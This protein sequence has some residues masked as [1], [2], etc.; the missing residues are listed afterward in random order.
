MLRRSLRRTPQTV[1]VA[2]LTG[3]ALAG[4]S[5][6]SAAH[7]AAPPKIVVKDGLTQPVFS[8]KDAIREHV[9]VEAGLDTDGDGKRD[10][11]NV[12]IVRPKES[13]AGLKVPVIMDASPYYDNLGRG[14][15]SEKK[16]YDA[17]GN[18][19]KFPLFYDNYFV[20]RGYAFLAV[21]AIGSN[22]SDGCPGVGESD[23]L[24]T[25]AVIDWLNGRAKA[26]K[27]DG[28]PV[29][30]SWT[31]GRTGM[32]GKSWDGTLANGVASTGVRGLET[33]VP[34]SAISSWYDYSRM[35]GV[36][37]WED[38]QPYLAD[39]VDTDP[40]AKCASVVAA[41]DA[42]EDDAT[43]DYNDYW[44]HR[45]YRNGT[46]GNAKNVRA[47]VF[48]YHGVNDLNV[49]DNHFAQWW[50]DLGKN[51]VVRKVWLSQTGH[52]DPFDI[53]R[54]DWVN[55]LHKWFDHELQKINNDALREPRADIEVGPDKWIT[56][57]S[58]PARDSKRVS[59]VPA[60][61]GS[62]GTKPAPH[63]TTGAFT[64]GP[65]TDGYGLPEADM[66]A[67]PTTAN[68]NR[69]AYV[70]A[71]LPATGRL[72]GTPDAKIKVKLDKPDA[73]VTALLV[74]YGTD[75]R[76]DYLG[77][78]SG[79]QTLTTEDCHGESIPTDD[80]CYKQTR[81]KTVT[82]DV[83]VVARGWM[84][85]QNR[86]SL[87][88]PSPLTPGT[89]YTVRWNTLSQEYVFKKGHRVALVLSGADY[90]YN[91]EK[92]TGAQVTIDLSGTS[93]T[94]PIVAGG[95]EAS[96]LVAPNESKGAWRGPQHVNLPRQ[97]KKLY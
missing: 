52:V 80:A 40:P 92:A 51:G 50:S 9:Y 34:I 26:T 15:E 65:G 11:V 7:A 69:L 77:A 84:D 87:S 75:T 35:N 8:Y 20:P 4:V 59:L 33:I 66:V 21:D 24:G 88:K 90:D 32:I 81:T 78:G 96:T 53:R 2:V 67:D 71:P 56:Q 10:R 46:F 82:S 83:N 68:P 86:S 38:E 62:L 3:T 27:A 49:K 23:V 44:N 42:G 14:N 30:A 89:F 76:V 6:L 54:D 25:K 17:A 64:D 48:F 43:G 18:P 55:T 95:D 13:D 94:V 79:I 97:E 74:D 1:A 12:D 63:G 73:N 57:S 85:L 5:G 60:A 39:L 29:K 45:N 31:T 37:Y 91:T 70:S 72:S 41:H 16:V 61:D 22:K 19:V 58:W 36:K 47:S 28:T 93:I